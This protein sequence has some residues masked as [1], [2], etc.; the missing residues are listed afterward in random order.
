MIGKYSVK[1][2][3]LRKAI[4]LFIVILAGILLSL[5]ISPRVSSDICKKSGRHWN[6]ATEKC[7]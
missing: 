3:P 7:E 1:T 5:V 4:A 2:S 6:A